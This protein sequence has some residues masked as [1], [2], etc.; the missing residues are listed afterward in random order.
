VF[1]PLLLCCAPAA[2]PGRAP[3]ANPAF[4]SRLVEY[5]LSLPEQFN[6]LALDMSGRKVHQDYIRIT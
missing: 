2:A 4:R 5:L 1:L 3:A 6:K